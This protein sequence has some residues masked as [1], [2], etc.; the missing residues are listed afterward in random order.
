MGTSGC[1]REPEQPAQPETGVVAQV[2]TVWPKS[3]ADLPQT[4]SRLLEGMDSG[5]PLTEDE[6]K[7]RNTWILWTAG[8]QHFWDYLSQHSY[9]VL[10]LL[11]TLSIPRDKRFALTGLIN[12]P[13]FKKAD[14]PDAYGLTLD[15]WDGQPP[16]DQPDPK[17]YGRSSGV[18]GLRLFD[19]PEFD[20]KAK[21]K[22]DS[23]KFFNDPVYASDPSVVRPYTIGMSCGFCHVSFNPAKPPA[24]P[25]SPKYE[26]LSSNVGA[27]YLW[28]SRVFG[29]DFRAENFVYQLMESNPPGALDTSLIASDNVNAPRTMNAIY[30]VGGRLDVAKTLGAREKPV[31]A[32]LLLPGV[33][34]G[35][36][37]IQEGVGADGLLTT[38]HILKDGADSIGLAGALARVFINI[39]EYHEE[40]IKHFKP[41][42]GGK[43]T[44]MNVDA[45][46]KN[47]PYWNA[48]LE[49]LANLASFFLKTAKA[50]HLE[51]APGGKSYLTDADPVL[52]KGKLVF[53]DNCAS[54]H[55]S[56]QPPG[57]PPNPGYFDDSY[58]KWT[59]SADYKQWMRAEVAKDDFR[60]GNYFSTDTRF[61]I[62]MIGTNA[63][64]SMGTNAIRGHIWD[65]FSSETYKTLPPVGEIE[66]V[67]PIDGHRYKWTPPG[68]GRG[69]LRAPSLASL[70]A[71]APFFV[72]NT[73]GEL[74]YATDDQGRSIL[75]DDVAT[76][77]ARMRV[78][79][80]SIQQLLWPEKR[81]KDPYLKGAGKIFRTSAESYLT[82]SVG[83]L[84]DFIKTVLA[85]AG[86]EEIRIGPFPKGTPINLLGNIDMSAGEPDSQATKEDM[87]AA[88]AQLG[89]KLAEIKLV[90]FSEEKTIRELEKVV[91][92]L[93]KVNKCPDFEFNRGHLFGTTLP[94][95]DKKALIAFLKTL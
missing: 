53:A 6:I 71:S 9:G 87:I 35:V 29:K 58:R 92:A 62:K 18:V 20:D 61:S 21:K 47:S 82:V 69:Y 17:V 46:N 25:S 56:K 75:K 34:T 78:F 68:G 33:Q 16:A 19:N 79:D 77:D 59:Q 85:A 3:A 38:P 91:P 15:V 66:V 24:N 12:E 23:N 10:D 43:Q 30:E 51:D 28:V 1:K 14:K 70:W 89:I 74:D 22:W 2:D 45:A 27:E 36:P 65:S 39:G 60:T 84:P 52:K 83:V 63:C 86:K 55:S 41:L 88:L 93:L 37:G 81:A 4:A 11:K 50:I 64:A 76:V 67:H 44:P 57:A 32:A 90:N 80:R 49:R 54:C 73:L 31:G 7:G 40:W 95:A 26:N 48:T 72:S 8:N 5:I 94:D 13:G 42:I